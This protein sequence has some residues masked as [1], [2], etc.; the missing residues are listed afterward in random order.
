MKKNATYVINLDLSKMLD[1]M[2]IIFCN[3]ISEGICG[4]NKFLGIENVG[5]WQSSLW[6]SFSD[7]SFGGKGWQRRQTG[8]PHSP[9]LRPSWGEGEA[10]LNWRTEVSK[11]PRMNN[12]V[13]LSCN[14]E[15]GVRGT[16]RNES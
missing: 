8:R 12:G 6:V 14:T 4:A 9:S 2:A 16:K 1:D 15:K 7:S 5:G 3:I 13:T 11:G 10:A